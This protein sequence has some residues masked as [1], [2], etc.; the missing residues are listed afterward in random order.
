MDTSFI[1]SSISQRFEFARNTLSN[2]V[3]WF[4]WFVLLNYGAMSWLATSAKNTPHPHAI[5]L[6]AAG[7]LLQNILAVIVCVVVGKYFVRANSRILEDQK[8][9]RKVRSIPEPTGDLAGQ[10]S[11]PSLL[12]GTVVALMIA[13]LTPMFLAWPVVIW[14][15]LNNKL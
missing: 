9:I 8:I 1:E 14:L 7:F 5:V 3:T 10:T 15:V 12:Y 4:S 13:A 6:V 11:L 2:L